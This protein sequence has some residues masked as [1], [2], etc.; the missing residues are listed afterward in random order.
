MLNL[1]FLKSSAHLLSK[2]SIMKDKIIMLLA[3]LYTIGILTKCIV[4][5]TMPSAQDNLSNITL[6]QMLEVQDLE[7][8]LLVTQPLLRDGGMVADHRAPE[9]RQLPKVWTRGRRETESHQRVSGA[10][11]L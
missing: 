3:L 7:M 10:K 6:T 1:I 11:S 2:T 9:T 8:L 4:Q 5:F